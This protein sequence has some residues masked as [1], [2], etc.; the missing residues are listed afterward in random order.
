MYTLRAGD[1]SVIAGMSGTELAHTILN[2]ACIPEPKPEHFYNYSR[3]P[4]YWTAWSLAYYQWVTGLRFVEIEQA[5]SIKHV[6]RLYDP[7]HEMDIQQF[8]DK[9]NQLYRTARPDTNLKSLRILAGLTQS[10]LAD[11]AQVPFARFSSMNSV[12][13]TLIRRRR[14]PFF[15][16]LGF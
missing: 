1:C 7:Y 10:M 13:K 16:W 11:E 3:S 6:Y 12:R 8:V 4:E 5:V 9:M 15:D 14:T 2:Q